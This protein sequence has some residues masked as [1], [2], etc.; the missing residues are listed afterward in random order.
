MEHGLSG[1]A[2]Y[3]VWAAE[4]PWF[5]KRMIIGSLLILFFI[6]LVMLIIMCGLSPTKTAE[7]INEATS[8]KADE[9]KKD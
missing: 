6:G 7:K 1:L 8:K 3:T 2:E 9:G 4:N 5:E